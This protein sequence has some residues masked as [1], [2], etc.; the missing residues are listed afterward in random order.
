MKQANIY[1]TAMLRKQ[2][3]GLIFVNDLAAGTITSINLQRAINFR[4]EF[5]KEWKLKIYSEN[6]KITGFK[7]GGKISKNEKWRPRT[8]KIQVTNNIKV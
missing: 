7:E 5:C 2:V 3:S 1:P 4:Q 6:T 8:E